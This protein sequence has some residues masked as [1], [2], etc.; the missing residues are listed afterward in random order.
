MAHSRIYQV[1]VRPISEDE[2]V[3]S[4]DFYENSDDFANYIGDEVEGD[5][6]KEDI[7]H[8]GE[9]LKDLFS[10][11]EDS[12]TLTYKG[13]SAMEAF[14]QAWADCLREEAA[15]VTAGNILEYRSRNQVRATCKETHLRTSYRFYIED[16]NELAEAAATLIAYVSDK[17]KTG[18]KLYVGA[19]IDYHY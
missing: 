19:V 17:M 2:Y 8:L 1:N 3:G 15:Q 13:E 6:R 11:D 16:Y 7:K 14:K 5:E 4:D 9:T 12:E 18:D 10:L